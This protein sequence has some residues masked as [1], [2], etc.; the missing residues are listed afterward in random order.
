[1]P[2]PI[3]SDV[4][5]QYTDDTKEGSII[6]QIPYDPTSAFVNPY[7][8]QYV[9]Q[10][11]RYAG[12]L[13]FR[14]TIVGNQTFSGLIGMAWQPKRVDGNIARVSELMKYSYYAENITLPSNKVM[15]LHDARNSSFTER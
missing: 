14:V 13:L 2:S 3:D 12:P 4:Q 9:G 5:Y 15:V 8:R 10:H 1:M 7:I 11:E 6:F